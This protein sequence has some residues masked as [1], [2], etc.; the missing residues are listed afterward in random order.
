[1]CPIVSIVVQNLCT[2][3]FS[4]VE[5]EVKIYRPD[6]KNQLFRSAILISQRG[7]RTGIQYQ[8]PKIKASIHIM[9]QIHCVNFEI[10]LTKKLLGQSKPEGKPGVGI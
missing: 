10:K 1:M 5:L 7:K 2:I 6:R 4:K 3:H 9:M 8:I